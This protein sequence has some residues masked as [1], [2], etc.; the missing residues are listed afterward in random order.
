MASTRSE[1][2]ELSLAS[3][4]ERAIDAGQRFIAD[5]I[6]L[7]RLDVTNALI[8]AI[9]GSGLLVVGTV[10]GAIGWAGLSVA[11]TLILNQSIGNWAAS[12]GAI[13]ALNVLLGGLLSV[14]GVRKAQAGAVAGRQ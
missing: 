8:E 14:V 6:D 4:A 12:M 3:A 11:A 10:M 7:A 13:G 9:Q 5:R 1:R 2:A